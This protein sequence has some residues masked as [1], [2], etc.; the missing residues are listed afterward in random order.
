MST[1]P[2]HSRGSFPRKARLPRA[3][4]A[5]QCTAATQTEVRTS[6]DGFGAQKLKG[7][8]L[9]CP[10]SQGLPA[11][12]PGSNPAKAAFRMRS[13]EPVHNRPEKVPVSG[14]L[15]G[16]AKTR[17]SVFGFWQ[18]AEYGFYL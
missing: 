6:G 13:L 17:T 18:D 8:K 15:H 12:L 1:E 10:V 5:E 9:T 4:P 7:A 11:R 2:L 14:E 3:E 16:N